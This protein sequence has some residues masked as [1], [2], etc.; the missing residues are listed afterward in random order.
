MTIE[1]GDTILDALEKTPISVRKA[2]FKQAKFLEQNL[3]HPSLH[4]KKCD[5]SGDY[6]QARVNRSWR[7]YFKIE[8]DAYVITSIIPY[9]K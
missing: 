3:H 9:P 7:F 5:A 4:A 6:W 2:F 1:Y 8:D